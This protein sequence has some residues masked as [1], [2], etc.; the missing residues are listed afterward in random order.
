MSMLRRAT[1]L[2]DK[3]RMGRIRRTALEE[4][5]LAYWQVEQPCRELSEVMAELAA[6]APENWDLNAQMSEGIEMPYDS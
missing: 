5:Q 4:I 3:A 6:Y 2:L 1:R